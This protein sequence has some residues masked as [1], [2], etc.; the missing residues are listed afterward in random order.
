MT[1]CISS[2]SLSLFLC[3]SSSLLS[4]L[5]LCQFFYLFLSLFLSVTLFVSLCPSIC[6]RFV[7]LCISCFFYLLYFEQLKGVIDRDLICPGLETCSLP[8]GV[9]VSPSNFFLFISI[10]IDVIDINDNSP[11]FP[12]S[13]LSL[14]ISESVLTGSSFTI[15]VADDADSP[16]NS[17]QRYFLS[18]DIN[19]KFEMG[20]RLGTPTLSIVNS[21]DR[22]NVSVYQLTMTAVDGGDPPRSSSMAINVTIA[23]VNDNPP[24]FSRAI[25]EAHLLENA[26]A[27]ARVLSVEAIDQDEGNNA[28]ISYV[29][30]S[31]D[32]TTKAPTDSVFLIDELTGQISL[33]PEQQLDR[34]TTAS[35]S[36]IVIARDAGLPS[37]S[38][39]ATAFI[40]VDDVNDN[41]P[42]LTINTMTS[43]GQAQVSEGAN[44]GTFV[45]LISVTDA[46]WG[47]NG[48]A[49]C[50]LET[51]EQFFQLVRVQ[52]AKY[53]LVTTNVILDYENRSSCDV[54]VT[55]TDNGEDVRL[56]SDSEMQ[57][58][59]LDVND[60]DPLFNTSI[61][62]VSVWENN[63]PGLILGIQVI[64]TDKDSDSNGR[65][66]YSILGPGAEL[67][68]ID[69]DS[70]IIRLNVSLDHETTPW[71]QFQVEARDHGKP[72]RF[73]TA[74]VQV[75]V[76]DLN[77]VAPIFEDPSSYA[78]TV[79]ENLPANQ[80]IGHVKA[81]DPES[82][83]HGSVTYSLKDG[84]SDC[85]A[86]NAVSGRI[87]TTRSLDRE[88]QEV[89]RFIVLAS[90]DGY[91][92]M[93]SSVEVRVQVEDINDNRPTVK[94]PRT[95]NNTVYISNQLLPG[96]RATQV[97]ASDSDAGSNALLSFYF[98]QTSRFF[99]LDSTTG[100]I[101][102]TSDLS[103]ISERK[104]ELLVHVTDR[105]QP[106]LSSS[107]NL[108]LVVN[109]TLSIPPILSQPS[110]G[111]LATSPNLVVVI[112]IASLSGLIAIL[113]LTAIG[114]VLHQAH[115]KSL[116]HRLRIAKP[117]SSFSP[118]LRYSL[119]VASATVIS[120]EE[121]KKE[122][123]SV[124]QVKDSVAS[125][126]DNGGNRNE[127]LEVSVQGK[128][129]VSFM[130][131]A[132]MITIKGY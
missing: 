1:L 126:A 57:V 84:N 69:A 65:L 119:P 42:Q 95:D 103:T 94:F 13:F 122:G 4:L 114:C 81:T 27:G 35:Y 109:A 101:F 6:R 26:T 23:D 128:K 40:T 59:V 34:E 83:S 86:V 125:F 29:L 80:T 98:A 63:P 47:E 71:L 21:L 68:Y 117:Q 48:N 108:T 49:S 132:I 24:I 37:L 17:V 33:A 3:V 19:Q 91:A 73:C 123:V 46:D 106:V 90:N 5:S 118:T 11:A 22:E 41:S 70:G 52:P 7:H 115:R 39:T 124:S 15:P 55:C 53:K 43:D 45:A 44:P 96:Q 92:D 120:E 66:S 20:T 9:G 25:Y 74:L 116:A 110:N 51:E 38:S 60:N 105:G 62:N 113:L 72:S 82:G 36:L 8:L 93:T 75:N 100:T 79:L 88:T 77:D 32:Q 30:L 16:A 76:L 14:A 107:A 85:F 78:F 97:I 61:Y 129:S 102:V 58:R 54:R 112:C 111:L 10:Q 28:K 67:F 18:G 104:F 121:R 50:H 89:H 56:T 131:S 87:W 2:L 99:V 130:S 12:V 127:S 64:A 31:A